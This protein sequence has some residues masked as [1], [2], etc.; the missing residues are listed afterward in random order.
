M[1]WRNSLGIN[2]T[3]IVFLYAG[4]LEYKKAPELLLSAFRKISY[5]NAHLIILGNGPLE[6]K[7]KRKI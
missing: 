6:I 3:D 4:K 2:N 5:P 1:E 7:L